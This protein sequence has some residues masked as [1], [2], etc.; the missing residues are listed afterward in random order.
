[1]LLIAL[2]TQHYTSMAHQAAVSDYINFI[3]ENSHIDKLLDQSNIQQLLEEERLLNKEV[4]EILLDV[5]II[6]APQGLALRGHAE[7]NRDFNQIVALL[8]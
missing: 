3:D 2:L 1:M 5:T 8:D 4:I 6:L 7:N